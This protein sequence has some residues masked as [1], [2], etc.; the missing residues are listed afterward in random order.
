LKTQ[1]ERKNKI[2]LVMGPDTSVIEIGVPGTESCVLLI[3]ITSPENW[4]V[5][6]ITE[7]K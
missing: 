1:K 5:P 4:S 2:I 3:L 6:E 7:N